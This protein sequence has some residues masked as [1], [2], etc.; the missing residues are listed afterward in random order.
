MRLLRR[1]DR[2]LAKAEEILLFA[3]LLGL[4]VLAAFQVIWRNLVQPMTQRPPLLWADEVL[5]HVTFV[6]GILGGTLATHYD[7]HISLDVLSRLFAQR[8]RLDLGLRILVRSVAIFVCV[9][10]ARGGLQQV[11]MKETA[12]EG[13]LEPWQWQIAIPA[14]FGLIIVHLA[15]RL[16]Y[17]AAALL[18]A[19]VKEQPKP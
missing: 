11:R 17:D 7:K 3:M 4:L 8:K 15:L 12:F 10:L 6:L 9:L 19:K 18:G 16:V 1:I 2:G 5:K 13:V 14:L